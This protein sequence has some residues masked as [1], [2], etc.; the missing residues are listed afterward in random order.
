M[1]Q[2]HL[3]TSVIKQLM[4]LQ[5]CDEKHSNMQ[6]V[7]RR[8][9]RKIDKKLDGHPA[10]EKVFYH[11]TRRRHRS[12]DGPRSSLDAM[13][14]LRAILRPLKRQRTN[15]IPSY[16]T[17]V[18]VG[19]HGLIECKNDIDFPTDDDI[20]ED[21]FDKVFDSQL[22][23]AKATTINKHNLLLQHNTDE[24]LQVLT[25]QYTLKHSPLVKFEGEDALVQSSFTTPVL[26]R[27]EIHHFSH[28][29]TAALSLD[30]EN[31]CFTFKFVLHLHKSEREHVISVDHKES[32]SSRSIQIHE[33]PL[34]VPRDF[35]S[36]GDS[37]VSGDYQETDE[38]AR[39]CLH[40][41]FGEFT[42]DW[43]EVKHKV[44]VIMSL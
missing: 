34:S 35:V 10:G 5:E 19:T 7:V 1:F 29:K 32:V 30:G 37:D 4:V 18:K 31:L 2:N 13:Q 25:H 33:V 9:E 12:S 28:H 11:L 3:S 20:E 16:V 43:V 14:D 21:M 41:H 6:R 38:T 23:M 17:Y 36:S 26:K 24:Y 44:C 8:I 22:I 27:L 40:T 42:F 39:I 15:I